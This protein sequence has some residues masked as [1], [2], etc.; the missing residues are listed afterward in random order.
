MLYRRFLLIPLVIAALSSGQALA[1][2]PSDSVELGVDVSACE[3]GAAVDDRFAVFRASMP[4]DAPAVRLAMNFTL[5]QRPI[6]DDSFD[7]VDDVD[8]FGVWQKSATGAPGYIASKRVEGL[9]PG[10]SYRVVVRYRWY[11]KTGKVLR[12]AKR[13]SAQCRQPAATSTRR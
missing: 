11:S 9:A 2:D 3:T 13:T 8:T 7:E 10:V 6:G 4:A 12:T 5:Q 1:D